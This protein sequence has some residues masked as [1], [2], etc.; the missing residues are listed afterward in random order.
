MHD[1]FKTASGVRNS[2]PWDPWLPGVENSRLFAQRTVR[3]L[4]GA[5]GGTPPPPRVPPV[6]PAEGGPN[7]SVN[8][9]GTEGAEA[10]LWLSASNIGRWGWGLLRWCTAV[11]I[12]P[13]EGGAWA[14]P[15][16]S[17]PRRSM[18]ECLPG[19]CPARYLCIKYLIS[20]PRFILTEGSPPSRPHRTAN[21]PCKAPCISRNTRIQQHNMSL[22]PLPTTTLAIVMN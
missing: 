12:H 19:A 2:G 10:K 16:E 8:P 20:S 18:G 5:E 14:S 17:W 7:L 4:E 3:P 6:V 22:P 21:L 11:P 1:P 9:L 13:R 15:G